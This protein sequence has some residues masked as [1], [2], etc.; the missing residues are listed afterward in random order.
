MHGHM[1]GSGA[2]DMAKRET[3]FSRGKVIKEASGCLVLAVLCIF[4]SVT[5]SC[6][7]ALTCG[8]QKP[9]RPLRRQG[10]VSE[11]SL[12]APSNHKSLCKG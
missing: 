8:T 3:P 6:L 11:G 12:L 1:V 9:Q 7:E 4:C 5:G 2:G 10:G